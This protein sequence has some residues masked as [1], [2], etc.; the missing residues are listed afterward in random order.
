MIKKIFTTF[1]AL[2]ILSTAV[3]FAADETSPE[4]YKYVSINY[5]YSI[6]CPSTPR[7]VPAEIFF[8][9]NTKKGDVLVFDFEVA[10]DGSYNVKRAWVIL[11]DAFNTNAVPDFNVAQKQ[12]IDQY[13]TELQK[14]GYEGLTLVDIT[15]DNKGILG[16]TAKEI[17]IDE[18]GDGK[19][20]GIATA[21]YQSAVAFFRMS[22]NRCV[23]AQLIGSNDL[24][25]AAVNNFRTALSTIKKVD[26]SAKNT[27][28]NSKDK[29]NKKSKD[30]KS[31]K[32]KKK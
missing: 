22:D 7:V 3:V 6:E 27:E 5:G 17:E 30:K 28:D 14:Q 11:F 18:D 26:L 4:P 16:I 21:D 15:K 25:E 10:N 23:A 32:D 29:D 13:L 24:N 1:I 8:D 9:D 31:K 19:P 12:L 20:D 2:M